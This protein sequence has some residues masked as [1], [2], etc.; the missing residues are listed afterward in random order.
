MTIVAKLPSMERSDWTDEPLEPDA[1]TE[2]TVA[3][4]EGKRRRLKVRADEVETLSEKGS[5]ASSSWSGVRR[6]LSW[7]GFFKV[8]FT[9]LALVVGS[10]VLPAVTKQWSDRTNANAI[11][12]EVA[13]DVNTAY[14]V[15]VFEGLAEFDPAASTRPV[16]PTNPPPITYSKA[17]LKWQSL[18]ADATAITYLYFGDAD[19]PLYKEWVAFHAAMGAFEDLACV[20]GEPKWDRDVAAVTTYLER[21]APTLAQA[22]SPTSAQLKDGLLHCGPGQEPLAGR[23]CRNNMEWAAADF[24]YGRNYLLGLLRTAKP[25]GYSRG[26]HD[27]VSDVFAPFHS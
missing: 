11:R 21:W 3:L 27:F 5:D 6:Y 18:S 25:K 20:C 10:L 8:S 26:F 16:D 22:K 24:S 4:P 14:D 1:E 23:S 7:K 9:V 15:P 19:S 2:I 17:Y 13:L 12:S